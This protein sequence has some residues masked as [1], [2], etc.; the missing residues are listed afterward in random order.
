VKTEGGK[1]FFREK[2]GVTL[3]QSDFWKSISFGKLVK[4]AAAAAEEMMCT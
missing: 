1:F 3:S 4:A 2:E